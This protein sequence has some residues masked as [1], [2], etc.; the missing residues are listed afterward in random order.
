MNKLN[1][2]TIEQMKGSKPKASLN[3]NNNE[4]VL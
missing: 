1:R 3:N 4:Y 2:H